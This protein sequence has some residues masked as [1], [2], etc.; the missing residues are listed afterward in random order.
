MFLTLVRFMRPHTIIATTIQVVALFLIASGRQELRFESLLPV[1]LTLLSCLALNVY[2][3][4]LNQITDIDIDRVNK[5]RLPLASQ[6][7]SLR[8]GWI[9]VVVT[10]F[11]AVI[12]GLVAGPVLL[13]TV[14]LIMAI[15]TMYS[16]PPLRLKRLSVWA[17]ISIA[18][19]R[20]V[21]ANVGVALHYDRVFGGLADLT[22][23]TLLTLAMFF[24][25]FG[26]V[27]AIYKDIPDLMGDHLHGIQTFTVR[28]GPQGALN[29][30]RLIL[31]CAYIGIIAIALS[32]FPG[33]G[34]LFLLATQLLAVAVFWV[35]CRQVNLQ[36]KSSITHFYL[37]LWGLFYAQYIVLSIFQV[38]RG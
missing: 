15:G 38:A 4:G 10:G 12:G 1:A 23:P 34:S 28:L 37:L 7:M 31:T 30:G 26:L 6:E 36:L 13:V 8:Q 29:L 33:V 27:I 11:V 3:V 35:A 18:L 14:I 21:I 17:A 16:L 19:A 32:Q 20:G 5:P 9:V 25:G 2:V 22:L 24:F